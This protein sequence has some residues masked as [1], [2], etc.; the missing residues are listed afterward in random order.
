MRDHYSPESHHGWASCAAEITKP[1]DLL[2]FAKGHPTVV[3]KKT[4]ESPLDSK[5]IKPV[6]PKGNHPWMFIGRTDA[7][8]A[9][10]FLWLL[11]SKS[12]LIRKDRTHQKRPW[13]RLRAEGEGGD[14]RR[15]GWIASLAQWVWALGDSEGQG[16]WHAAVHGLA[17]SQKWLSNWTTITNPNSMCESLCISMGSGVT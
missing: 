7:E 14:R 12:Q 4:L 9:A 13:E 1:C 11:D 10:P 16:I 5:E 15:D 6:H 8:T 2:D 3:L 17:K